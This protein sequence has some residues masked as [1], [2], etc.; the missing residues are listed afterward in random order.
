MLG[1]GESLTATIW[2]VMHLQ[3][4]GFLLLSADELKKRGG[5]YTKGDNWQPHVVEDNH[6]VTGLADCPSSMTTEN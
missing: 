3:L 4:Y 1:V 2:S 6:L 5:K